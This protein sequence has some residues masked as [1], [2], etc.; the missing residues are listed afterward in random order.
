MLARY[1]VELDLVVSSEL[2]H[3]IDP[4]VNMFILD[5]HACV[6]LSVSLSVA[7]PQSLQKWKG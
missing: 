4:R 1:L 6:C 5:L 7:P 2:A 3:V